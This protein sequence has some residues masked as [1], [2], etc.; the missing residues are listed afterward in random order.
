MD[1]KR[2]AVNPVLLSKIEEPFDRKRPR[3]F[4]IYSKTIS[5]AA[6]LG[7]RGNHMRL[8]MKAQTLEASLSIV[9]CLWNTCPS[10]AEESPSP[11]VKPTKT[12]IMHPKGQGGSGEIRLYD[13]GANGT[14]IAVSVLPWPDDGAEVLLM[15]GPCAGGPSRAI[16]HLEVEPIPMA[17]KADGHDISPPSPLQAVWDYNSR[18]SINSLLAR[19]LSIVVHDT[20]TTS[21]MVRRACA[22][23]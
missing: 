16:A 11:F 12:F 8:A 3:R 20:K 2:F 4:G 19:G 5:S 6:A 23:Q 18:S 14:R 22:W 7:T 17:L 9:F 21:E 15:N 1:A 13:L 10:G